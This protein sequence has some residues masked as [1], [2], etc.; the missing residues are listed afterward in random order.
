MDTSIFINILFATLSIFIICITIGFVVGIL[1]VILLLKIVKNEW[2]KIA[3]D[4]DSVRG[5]V[6]S[7]EAMI[8]SL[9]M[10]IASFFSN[11]KKRSKKE[12]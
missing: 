9:A 8:T 6:R 10:Y 1:Y 7:G 5:K 3:K 12:N 11:H 2:E 4:I